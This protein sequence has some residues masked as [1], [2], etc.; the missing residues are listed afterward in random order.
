MI[1]AL[2]FD[3]DG[4]ILDTEVPDFEAWREIYDEYG[5][6]LPRAEWCAVIG[7]GASA[8]PFS[9]YD[10][11]E[12]LLGRRLDRNAV[13]ARRRRR[14]TELI[15][16]QRILA[17]VET[18]IADAHRQGLKIGVASS[19]DR[20]WVVGHLTRIGLIHHFA[21]VKTADDVLRTKPEPDLYLAATEALCVR[22][23]EAV[24]LEDSA[25]GVT[26]ARRAGLYCV[27]VPN[28]MTNHMAF[29]HAD[30]RLDS[31]AE[32]SLTNLVAVLKASRS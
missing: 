6:V 3:F 29:D 14:Y 7:L 11:L 15:H 5:C 2:V 24:A 10:H 9:P 12:Q 17:G 20:A 31:L 16:A 1:E 21:V 26:A 23:E 8:T 22:P 13:K 25:H 18:L 28:P 30:L 27:A 19:S 32:M 4:L